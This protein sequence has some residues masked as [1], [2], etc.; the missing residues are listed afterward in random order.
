MKFL[1]NGCDID[2]RK[3]SD[4]FLLAKI[5]METE[6][7]DEEKKKLMKYFEDIRY[8]E[9]LSTRA[10]KCSVCGFDDFYHGYEV[11]YCP[12]CGVKIDLSEVR[13]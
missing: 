2:S 6:L 13:E 7:T 5:L 4:F 10:F 8:G 11:Y 3:Y 9:N 1:L 12:N